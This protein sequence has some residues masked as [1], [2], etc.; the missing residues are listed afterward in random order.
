M[1]CEKNP[2]LI[3]LNLLGRFE[4]R[5]ITCGRDRVRVLLVVSGVFEPV[6]AEAVA[7]PELFDVVIP[8]WRSG[9][10]NFRRIAFVWLMR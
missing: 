5:L 3:F 9:L 2:Y 6:L 10:I 8:A 7:R 4:L 1:G